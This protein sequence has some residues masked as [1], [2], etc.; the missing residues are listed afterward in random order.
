MRVYKAGR[1]S[2]ITL[3]LLPDSRTNEKRNDVVDPNFAKFRTNKAKVISI[4][5]PVTNENLDYDCSAY[6]RDFKYNVDQIVKVTDYDENVNGVCTK[7]I[8]YFKTYEA[9]LSYYWG[10]VLRLK[11]KLPDGTY[12]FYHENGRKESQM[13]CI[14]G[15]KHGK[16]IEW[17]SNGRKGREYN[18][19]NEELDGKEYIWRRDGTK[20]SECDYKNG[21]KHGKYI[22]WYDNGNK[23]IECNY[24]NNVRTSEY[25]WDV[26]GNPIIWN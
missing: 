18:Y 17:Y 6:D 20:Y 4:N 25:E 14:N 7:G 5:D 24:E 13:T 12:I 19:K 8:H 3:E 16:Y 9:A 10:H 23:C 15:K 22:E 26:Y 11:G 2:I 21:K 1:N